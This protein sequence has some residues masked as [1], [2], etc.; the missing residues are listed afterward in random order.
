[1]GCP[2]VCPAGQICD[3]GGCFD[4]N[5]VSSHTTAAY[6]PSTP[7]PPPPLVAAGTNGADNGA[8]INGAGINSAGNN[9]A[10]G[11]ALLT[12]LRIW[13]PFLSAI[14]ASLNGAK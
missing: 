6:C 8:G 10:A 5:G 14:A 7:T 2:Q 13:K 4:A 3:G 11:D 12:A 9:G 1:M